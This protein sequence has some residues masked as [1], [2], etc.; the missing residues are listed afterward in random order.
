M[1][2]VETSSIE[3]FFFYVG[4][5][6]ECDRVINI[7]FF[8]IHTPLRFTVEE[9]FTMMLFYSGYFNVLSLLTI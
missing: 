9:P 5:F 7:V 6:V 3:R 1:L 4:R 8:V 2:A